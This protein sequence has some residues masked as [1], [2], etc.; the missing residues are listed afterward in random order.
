MYSNLKF[1][2]RSK[3]FNFGLKPFM[4]KSKFVLI[5]AAVLCFLACGA[6]I[7]LHDHYAYT[8]A[9]S[10][11]VDSLKLMDKAVEDY[12]MHEDEVDDL[13]TKIEKAHEYEKA[14]PK[15]DETIK[16]WEILKDPDKDL[17][18][19]FFKMWK[20]KGKVSQFFIEEKKKQVVKAF[21]EI[22]ELE[23]VKL[24]E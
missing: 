23:S 5:A 3:D 22:I 1:L 15:N 9:T 10:L 14:R 21:D 7:S 12:S 8:Q 13:L 16:Q 18:G 19:G 11:K 6:S 17:L 2:K 24:R 4:K 20:E